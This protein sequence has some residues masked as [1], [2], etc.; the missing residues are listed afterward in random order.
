MASSPSYAHAN[1]SISGINWFI[2]NTFFGNGC[3][4]ELGQE[5][6]EKETRIFRTSRSE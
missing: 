5:L 6:V 4:A 3:G 1:L 2:K